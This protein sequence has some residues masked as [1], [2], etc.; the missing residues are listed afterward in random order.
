MI[1]VVTSISLAK[2]SVDGSATRYVTVKDGPEATAAVV[3]GSDVVFLDA[4]DAGAALARVAGGGT[5]EE[6]A[7]APFD[8][9]G[10]LPVVPR[11][12]KVVC[13]GLNYAEHIREMG[14]ELP[15]HPTLFA[16]FT[17]ALIGPADDIV[18]PPESVQVDWEAELCVVIGS[19]VRRATPDQ[20]RAAI[21]GYTVL[22][23]V[24]VRD[25]QYR[26]LQ[27]LQ[28]KTFESTTPVGPWIVPRDEVDVEGGVEIRCEVNGEV[29]QRAS[30]DDL[31]FGPVALV[32][33]ISTIV[34]LQPGD[35]IS[36]GTPA[37]VGH[38]MDPPRFLADGDV[39]RTVIEGIGALENVARRET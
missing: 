36:T 29:V 25:W 12:S 10:L 34:T 7:L 33:Y 27:W 28:G 26:T 11:P 24:T 31:V 4:P 16:K 32:E 38:A 30:T 20:A 15:A 8:S 39:V 37:G 6:R 14:R 3:R 21:G 18:L 5:V 19:A 1:A 13:V 22:N 17:E 9:A 35:L 23:D 2:F